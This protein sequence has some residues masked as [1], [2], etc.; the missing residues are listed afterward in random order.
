MESWLLLTLLW[1]VLVGE[2]ELETSN[3]K[4]KTKLSIN[5]STIDMFYAKIIL[6]LLKR[7]TEG[8]Y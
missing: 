1:V 3:Q 6:V 8:K 5:V 4:P 7:R 2:G